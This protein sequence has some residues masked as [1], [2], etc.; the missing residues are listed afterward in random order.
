MPM[1]TPNNPQP[2][3]ESE[4]FHRILNESARLLSQGR[5]GEATSRLRALEEKA[6]G[7]LDVAINLGG[8][9]ILQRKWTQAV[10]LL[11]RALDAHPRNAMLWANLAAAELGALETSG[12][13]QQERAIEAY[14]QALQ[15]DPS[16]PNVH[17]H[18]GLIYKHRG[19]LNRASAFFQRAIEVHPGDRDARYWLDKMHELDM[20]QRAEQETD[21]GGLHTDAGAAAAGNG[22]SEQPG[23]PDANE[24][25]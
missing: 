4:E 21:G 15:V 2:Y 22:H 8:A 17:Y 9:L 16:A 12:P 11:R 20:Q 13:K 18:L 7:N 19:E 23:A 24:Q 1:T 25:P 14:Q 3:E 6:P 10:R 5:P